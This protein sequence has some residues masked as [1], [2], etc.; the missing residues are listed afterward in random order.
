LYEA[1]VTEELSKVKVKV[2]L[3][4]AMKARKGVEV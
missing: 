2:S 3:E 1:G 4:Q